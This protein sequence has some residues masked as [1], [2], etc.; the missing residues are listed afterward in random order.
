MQKSNDP[1]D[2]EIKKML[3]DFAAKLESFAGSVSGSTSAN[4]LS[5]PFPFSRRITIV[6]GARLNKQ[7]LC[8][9]ADIYAQDATF[10]QRLLAKLN[11]DPD[12]NMDP[13]RLQALNRCAIREL[14][15][16][17]G[18]KNASLPRVFH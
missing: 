2:D 3:G 15:E 1:E 10:A 5:E 8:A 13:P 14:V 17:Y 9:L 18:K 12:A 11:N 6:A 16:E 4:A 7:K